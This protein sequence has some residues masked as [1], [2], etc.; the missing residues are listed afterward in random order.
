MPTYKKRE[1]QLG[2]YWLSKRGGSPAYYRTWLDPKARQTR[3]AS[4]GTTDFEEAKQR[5]TDWFITQQRPQKEKPEDVSLANVLA[6]YYENHGKHIA[7][8]EQIRVSMR[9]LLEFFGDS[10]VGD[11]YSIPFQEQFQDW[12]RAKGQVNT[13]INRNLAVAQSAINRAWKRGELKSRPHIQMLEKE[14][15]EPR[16]RPLEVAEIQKLINGAP[17]EHLVDFIYWM[18]GTAARPSAI[19][20][21]T[22]EQVD[23]ENGIIHLNAQGRKQNKKRRPSVKLPEAL[24]NRYYNKGNYP[25]SGA[26]ISY[27]GEAVKSVRTAWRRTRT[28]VGLDNKVNMY[29][30]R[31]TA[32]RWMRKEGVPAWDVSAQLGHKSREFSM[33]ERYA[34]Y[35]PD[36]M[37]K[38]V[39]A[40]N[41][42][43][44]EIQGSK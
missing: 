29:S 24:R 28:K 15:S 23:F 16:G 30:L 14:A 37:E 32:A 18:V 21:L 25:K 43:L 2:D 5:L 1:Y 6:A 35:S 27:N 38:S 19:V 44:L 22:W 10:M 26:V 40:L 13:S 41:K 3:R 42:L 31:H 17:S 9:H 20:E 8:A 34:P 7:S 4:L 36:H 12:L 39:V 33:T 11:L